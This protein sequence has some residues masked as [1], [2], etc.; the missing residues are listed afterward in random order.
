[1]RLMMLAAA[2]AAGHERD[3]D[4]GADHSNEPD[5]VARDLVASPF[6]ERLVDAERVAE[7][8][9][10]GEVLFG[11]VEAMKRRELLGAQHAER[12]EEL[13]TDLVL[14]AVAAGRRRQRGALAL[15]AVEHPEQAIVLVVGMRGRREE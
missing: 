3:H 12:F 6:L 11:A 15:S 13:G 5:E 8:D 10:A 4:V 1:R 2:R 9:G 7:V 14:S